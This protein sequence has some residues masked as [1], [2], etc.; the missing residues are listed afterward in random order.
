MEH[1]QYMIIKANTK[2]QTL[3]PNSDWGQLKMAQVKGNQ[4]I[5]TKSNIF[6]KNYGLPTEAHVKHPTFLTQDI[7]YVT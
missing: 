5:Y 3:D 1:Y 2:N 4:K 6:K 7:S